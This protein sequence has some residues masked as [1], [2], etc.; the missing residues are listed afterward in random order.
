MLDIQDGV[1]VSSV[2][3]ATEDEATYAVSKRLALIHSQ[4]AISQKDDQLQY[5]SWDKHILQN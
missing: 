4:G 5:Y 3:A 1:V 2:V